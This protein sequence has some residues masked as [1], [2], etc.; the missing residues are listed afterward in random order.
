MRR[1][2]AGLMRRV[3]EGRKVGAAMAVATFGVAAGGVTIYA[4]MGGQLE[5]RWALLIVGACLFSGC[6]SAF[7]RGKL[8]LLPDSVVDEIGEDVPYSARYCTRQHLAEACRMTKPY[9]GD[10]YVAGEVAEQWRQ[11]NPKAFVEIVNGSGILCA[12]FGVLPLT[13][14]FLDNF[15]RGRVPDSRIDADCILAPRNSNEADH[16]YISGVVVRDPQ[17]YL[18]DKRV[19]VM[20]WA[21]IEY[22]KRMYGLRRKRILVAL[23]ANKQSQRLMEKLGF[24]QQSSA[25]ERADKCPLYSYDF[26]KKTANQILFRTGDLSAMCQC[27]L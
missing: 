26:T 17:T 8:K 19:R 3:W 18:G 25:G 10:Q 13:A 23:A 14:S 16:L 2:P 9:Y 21:M 1:V 6:A 27:V 11:K 24:V 7:V 15:L 22:L 5:M 12:C 20:L 4:A